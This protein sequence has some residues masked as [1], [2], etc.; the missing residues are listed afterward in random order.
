MSRPS[1]HA[2][3]S[4]NHPPALT[5]ADGRDDPLAVLFLGV[6]RVSPASLTAVW[7]MRGCA[8]SRASACGLITA[9]H[10]VEISQYSG[11]SAAQA[12]QP[13]SFVGMALTSAAG[14][15]SSAA[16]SCIVS[17]RASVVGRGW[18]RSRSLA[19]AALCKPLRRAAAAG[20]GR[21][22]ILSP[23][24]RAANPRMWHRT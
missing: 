18:S 10:P 12:S 4:C 11:C 24:P 22:A 5:V 1:T 6:T 20:E 21:G 2:T 19:T 15:Q 7:S 9:R 23:P 8:G 14:A 17:R 13:W 3:L 16:V